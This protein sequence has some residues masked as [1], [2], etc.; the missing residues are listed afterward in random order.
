MKYLRAPS[1]GERSEPLSSVVC[2]W[3]VKFQPRTHGEDACRVCLNR[4]Y[5]LGSGIICDLGFT[6]L[7]GDIFEGTASFVNVGLHPG[8]PAIAG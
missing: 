6:G 8:E 1:S 2:V 3:G 7:F 5:L 4:T